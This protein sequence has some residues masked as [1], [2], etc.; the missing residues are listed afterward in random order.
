MGERR[1][2][3]CGCR[4]RPEAVPR[5]VYCSGLCRSRHWRRVRR[6]RLRV[7]ALQQGEGR[8]VCGVEWVAGVDRRSNAVYCS[9]LCRKRAWR[10][11]KEAFAQA[12]D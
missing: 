11:R 1:C 5:A 4:L 3:G 10:R 7:A 6:I 8:R 12:S 9:P 2:P